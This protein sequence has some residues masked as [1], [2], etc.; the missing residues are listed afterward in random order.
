MVRKLLISFVA[1]AVLILGV[2]LTAHYTGFKYCAPN[3]VCKPTAFI[4]PDTVLGWTLRPGT[5]DV[6]YC[7][8]QNTISFTALHTTNNCR[9][10]TTNDVNNLA[11]KHINIYGGSV[12]Y[13][14]GVN[15]SSSFPF[16]VQQKMPDVVV[17]NKGVSAYSVLQ[18]YLRFK[19]DIESGE[20]ISDAVF[21]YQT[22]LDER[23][24]EGKRWEKAL[25]GATEVKSDG[26]CFVPFLKEDKDTFL[27]YK[28]A[29]RDLF[30][31][32]RGTN[33]SFILKLF[34]NAWLSIIT[35]KN[36]GRKASVYI[37]RQI[38][39]LAQANGINTT[40]F[41]LSNCDTEEMQHNCD[42]IGLYNT[43]LIV[44]FDEN[45]KWMIPHDG[46]LS[47]LGNKW[48]ADSLASCLINR[49]YK[50]Q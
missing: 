38:H 35:G 32:I 19:K 5:Y 39:D 43:S 16:L 9:Y 36:V 7:V 31:G 12:V 17:R 41:M 49:Q 50:R 3:F 22:E 34:E 37:M 18:M 14:L 45:S 10:T 20:K 21:V 4:M 40:I 24:V 15:D 46:H 13:G 11:K 1:V 27:L 47:E 42:S 44:D 8:Q 25:T 23:N 48:V 29:D 28:K 33:K 30:R 2:E 6:S 26:V